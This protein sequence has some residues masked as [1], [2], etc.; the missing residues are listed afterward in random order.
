M[1]SEGF[2]VQRGAVGRLKTGIAGMMVGLCVAC[3]GQSGPADNGIPSKELRG[4]SA[5]SEVNLQ[6][7]L[8]YIASDKLAGRLSL[9]PGDD[10]AIEWVADQFEK[11]GLTPAV[12]APDGKASYLQAVPLVEYKPDRAALRVTLTRGGAATVF[13]APQVV[14]A[15]K[16][17]I[18]LSAP[19]VFAGYG[20]TAPEL[21]YDDYKKIDAQGKIV[22]I[23]DHEPQEDDPKSIF[24]G[25][26]NTRYATTRVKLLNAQAHGAVAVLIVAEPNRKHLTNA[27]RAAKIYVG[28]TV[29]TTPLPVQALSD[30]EL[31]IPGLTVVDAVAAKLLET[32]GAAPS[33]LQADI[34]K[35]LTP[36]S[37]A[38]PDTSVA[39]HMKNESRMTGTSWNVAGL[40]EGSDPALAAETILISAHHDHDGESPKAGTEP[41]LYG[42]QPMDIWHGADDNGSGTVGV[43]ELAKAFAANKARP[44]R[45]IL[46]VVFASEERGL[47]GSYWMAAHPLRP[48]PTTVAMINFDMIGRNETASPQ[49]D[50]LITIP[51]DTTNRLN[52]IGA[53]YSPDYDKVVKQENEHIGLVLDDRFDH[54]SA[55]NV[56]FRSDQFPFVLKD[57]PAFWWFTGFHP[58]YHHTTD[59][60]DKINYVK[61]AKILRLAYLTAWHFGDA[62]VEPVFVASPGAPQ[63]K[64][65]N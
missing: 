49:T 20:I 54:E 65:S 52:L 21:G 8:S 51:A 56:F 29:R 41:D 40:L 34:D 46:F 47:L 61:M 23:F 14:G 30:D 1:A 63:S 6:K 4:F 48:L 60:A 53:L 32:A 9:R 5:I 64:P 62:D 59:T 26:G 7:N 31:H 33:K 25:T 57:I 42:R 13:Q 18:D 11:A 43:V 44:K 35:D 15:Y 16:N 39:I 28:G 17:D 22:L 27:E 2:K 3:A 50:G 12:T 58:D 38:L 45:S 24:N 36:Q 55:L 37:R 10:A 19:V